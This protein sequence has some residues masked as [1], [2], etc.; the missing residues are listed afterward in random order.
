MSGTTPLD[1][2]VVLPGGRF[3]MG[4]DDRDGFPADGEGPVREVTVRPFAID[5]C[6]VTND[7][8]A[9][10]GSYLCHESYCNRYRVAARTGNAPDAATGNLGFRCAA[11]AGPSPA[12]VSPA[13]PE[14]R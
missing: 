8:F 14:A 6:C 13:D 1:S 11:D 9:A 7:R 10:G 5:P 2:M 12:D 3:R 4:T